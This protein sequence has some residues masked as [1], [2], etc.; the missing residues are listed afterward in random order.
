M[1]RG[2]VVVDKGNFTGAKGQGRY[3]RRAPRS[4]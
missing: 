1:S 3:L 2:R 4:I